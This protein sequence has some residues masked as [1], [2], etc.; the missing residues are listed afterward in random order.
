MQ[1]AE[2][3]RQISEKDRSMILPI[4]HRV[5]KSRG[6]LRRILKEGFILTGPEYS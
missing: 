4:A 3:R 2:C 1:I 6:S 5:K